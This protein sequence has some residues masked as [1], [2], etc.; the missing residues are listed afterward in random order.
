MGI[1]T[2]YHN[3]TCDN[4]DVSEIERLAKAALANFNQSA[5]L[6]SLDMAVTLHRK[7]L[8]LRPSPHPNRLA[9]LSGQ[10]AALLARS[11][12]TGHLPNI[13]EAIS[14]LRE[15]IQMC[16]N[17][18]VS[19]PEL[20]FHLSAALAT[21]FDSTGQ[22]LYLCEAMTR[23]QDVVRVAYTAD[24][25]LLNIPTDLCD[26]FD[27][28][29]QITDLEAAISL[30]SEC[31]AR[32]PAHHPN[33]PIVLDDLATSLT[34]RFEQLG[35]RRALDEEILINRLNDKWSATVEEVRQL[36]GFQDFLRPKPVSILQE[37]ATNGPAVVL[38]IS[39][40]RTDA[41]IVT[42]SGVEHIPLLDLSLTEA[43]ILVN[44][45][46]A[47][48]VPEDRHPLLLAADREGIESL[49]QR[50]PDLSSTLHLLSLSDEAGYVDIAPAPDAQI[51]PDD[52][53]RSVL[54]VLWVSV[55]EPVIRSLKLEV[56]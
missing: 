7:A 30:F 50:Q 22:L 3:M 43:N 17:P 32:L 52:I 16:P 54:E 40:C 44:M 9:S 56:S 55:A 14:L 35:Q 8:L 33:Q 49:L 28:S 42:S 51:Q 20:L 18:E 31:L 6:P 2:E 24:S 53:L 41:L 1:S 21:R 37:A 10:A 29:C 12:R 5:K 46:R 27:L 23:L 25:E 45:I 47:A 34:A 36:D 48:T 26:Q 4:S 39:T 11:R 15:A 13:D 38:N 19:H